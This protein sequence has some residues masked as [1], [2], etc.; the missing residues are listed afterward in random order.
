M[1]ET[2]NINKKLTPDILSDFKSK[3]HEIEKKHK[4]NIK[5]IKTF[6]NLVFDR[7]FGKPKEYM[8]NEYIGEID[9]KNKPHGIG[10]IAYASENTYTGQFHNSLRHGLGYYVYNDQSVFKEIGFKDLKVSDFTKTYEGNWFADLYDGLGQQ[11]NFTYD[12][13]TKTLNL[14][15]K[16]GEWRNDVQA[17]FFYITN[18]NIFFN[19]EKKKLETNFVLETLGF[20]LDGVPSGPTVHIYTKK[21]KSGENEL[22]EDRMSGLGIHDIDKQESG[23]IHAFKNLKEW[24]DIPIKENCSYSSFILNEFTL[25]NNEKFNEKFKKSKLDLKIKIESLR[26]EMYGYFNKNSKNEDFVK[27]IGKT[28]SCFQQSH[29]MHTLQDIEEINKDIDIMIEN[30]QNIKKDLID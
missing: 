19:F 7:K 3:K 9:Q 25:H 26:H 4:L 6:Y 17:G 1:E 5:K 18:T 12:N 29:E 15:H 16:L 30:F 14:Y 8:G 10:H 24:E 13:K 11:Q 21:N 22:M 28:K 27:L 2:D 23:F 20:Y